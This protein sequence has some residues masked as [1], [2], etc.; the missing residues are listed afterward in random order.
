[1]KLSVKLI[2]ITNILSI[3]FIQLSQSI[4]YKQ[5]IS[6][7]LFSYYNETDI[8]VECRQVIHHLLD[9]SLTAQQEWRFKS[10]HC[11]E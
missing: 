3:V 10:N 4:R 5:L 7:Q 9:D 1:M 6:N 11:L 8:S 2:L